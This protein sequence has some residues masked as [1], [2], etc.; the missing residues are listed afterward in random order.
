MDLFLSPYQSKE[1]RN[2]PKFRDRISRSERFQHLS[3]AFFSSP[4]KTRTLSSV[5]IL[6]TFSS[7]MHKD[8]HSRPVS[9][10]AKPPTLR[11]NKEFPEMR[12]LRY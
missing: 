12:R 4:V 11:L 3:L 9:S 2:F 10:R 8:G 1:F 7:S 6:N 5:Y